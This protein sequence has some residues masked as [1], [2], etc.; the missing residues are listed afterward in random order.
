MWWSPSCRKDVGVERTKMATHQTGSNWLE[1]VEMCDS[2]HFEIS[3]VVVMEKSN[4]IL[5]DI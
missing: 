5:D 2:C 4:S 3:K 1:P